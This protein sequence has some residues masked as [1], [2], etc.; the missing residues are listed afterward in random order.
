M[1]VQGS[2]LVTLNGKEIKL[3]TGETIDIPIGSAHR[4]ANLEKESLVFIEIQTGNY[5]GEDDIERLEDDYG[6]A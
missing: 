4:I 5:F 1:I 3:G 6:R 2:A